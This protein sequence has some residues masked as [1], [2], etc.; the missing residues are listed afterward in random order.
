MKDAYEK[1]DSSQA[2]KPI[3]RGVFGYFG[4]QGNFTGKQGNFTG[5][6]GVSMVDSSFKTER[7]ET[8]L[9]P[10]LRARYRKH[11]DTL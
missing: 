4:K 10:S 2:H 5:V 9:W 8:A 7:N 1:N 3:I 11:I 6:W